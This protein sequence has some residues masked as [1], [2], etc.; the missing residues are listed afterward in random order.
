MFMGWGPGYV[1]A[2][3]PEREHAQHKISFYIFLC[4]VT[5][6]L[7]QVNKY[8]V[9]S[10]QVDKPNEVFFAAKSI[11]QFAAMSPREI[12]VSQLNILPYKTQNIFGENWLLAK[13]WL[14]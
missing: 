1:S 7:R 10:E 5:V 14:M 12:F 9:L 11:K 2:A 8:S 3:D 13:K 4:C 6:L